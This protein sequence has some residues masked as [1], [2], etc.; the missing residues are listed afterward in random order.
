MVLEKVLAELE[1]KWQRQGYGTIVGSSY[2]SPRTLTHVGFADDLTLVAKT[3]ESLKEMLLDLKAAMRKVGLNLHPEKC[4]VQTNVQSGMDPGLHDVGG[5]L[6]IKLLAEDEGLRI[7]GT[8]VA[9]KNRTVLEVKERLAGGWKKFH[10]LDQLLLNKNAS[11]KKRL[12]LFDSCVGSGVLWCNESWRLSQDEKRKIRST[13]NTMMRKIVA[14]RVQ[15]GENWVEWVKRATK[16]TRR[17]A[18][19]A[20]VRSW[21]KEHGKKK[22]EWAGHVQRRSEAQ[23]VKKV[24]QWRDS[25]W[26]AAQ[27]QG[28]NAY[29]RGGM[30]THVRPGRRR[31]LR[32]EDPMRK[33][34]ALRH[35]GEWQDLCANSDEGRERWRTLGAKFAIWNDT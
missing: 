5:G 35:I 1:P 18:K 30:R 20:G 11:V 34:A 28:G 9:L 26:G 13:Q 2:A 16:I 33:Y 7:L 21:V 23:W 19:E 4:K 32:W 22:W 27:P 29:A 14:V 15:N 3:W 17:W 24:T 25:Q 10:A 31:W 8:A 6:K 12:K